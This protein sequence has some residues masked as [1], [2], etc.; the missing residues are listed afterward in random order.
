MGSTHT[1][2]TPD[3]Q[4]YA[5]S[6]GQAYAYSGGQAYAQGAPASEAYGFAGFPGNPMLADAIVATRDA[7]L[8]EVAL[9]DPLGGAGDLGEVRWAGDG[10]PATDDVTRI[11]LYGA[12]VRASMA[13][14]ELLSSV[15][16]ESG[17]GVAV[18]WG[19]C[20]GST[21]QMAELVRM[22]RPGRIYLQGQIGRVDAWAGRRDVRVREIL[23]QVA[24]PVAY[25][26]S[27]MN[28]QAA[29]HR[30]TLEMLNVALQFCYA[31]GMHF[32]HALAVPR[33]AELSS[34]VQAVIEAPLHPS[35]PA[36]HAAES[37]VTATLLGAISGVAPDSPTA[38]LLRRLAHR[39]GENRV[40]AGVHYPI[41]CVAGRLLG[42]ALSSFLLARAGVNGVWWGGEFDGQSLAGEDG[43]IHDLDSAG[44]DPKLRFQGVG[45]TSRPA[46]AAPDIAPVWARMWQLA[47][48][49]WG[50]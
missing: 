11:G 10:L 7:L 2:S 6:G 30:Y 13:Q 20:R 50:Q 31:C 32:K 35:L 16:F 1:L 8:A 36:G 46:E 34:F 17:P 4:A 47:R 18:L 5:Y 44:H 14:L 29:R 23:T 48:A 38:E 26:A 43:A 40:V 19:K 9:P 33:P 42:D 27:V 49:E 45:C 37:H 41:D 28:L 24:P 3:G 12:Q 15:E 39:I 22:T 21:Y 25:F